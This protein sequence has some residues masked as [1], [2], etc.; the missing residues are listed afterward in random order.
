M[1]RSQ[2]QVVLSNIILCV[3]CIFIIYSLQHN[4]QIDDWSQINTCN[5]YIHSNTSN[6]SKVDCDRY[7]VNTNIIYNFSGYLMCVDYD[8]GYCKSYSGIL[9]KIDKPWHQFGNQINCFMN[10]LIF[11][12]INMAYKKCNTVCHFNGNKYHGKIHYHDLFNYYVKYTQYIQNIVA[13]EKNEKT[14]YLLSSTIVMLLLCI[15]SNYLQIFYKK[16]VTSIKNTL[17]LMFIVIAI[18]ILMYLSAKTLTMLQ[19]YKNIMKLIYL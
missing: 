10:C 11:N 1:N 7:I 12:G 9:Q 5:K 17:I 16:V 13:N 15:I 18:S 8:R 4:Y 2:N 14:F 3:S 19:T 6:T